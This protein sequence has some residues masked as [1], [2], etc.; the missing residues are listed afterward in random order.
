MS[1]HTLF[2]GIIFVLLLGLAVFFYTGGT[3]VADVRIQTAH[4]SDYP[5]VFESVVGVLRSGSAPQQFSGDALDDV[6]RYTLA[7]INVTLKNRGLFAAEWLDIRVEGAPGDVAVYSLTGEGSTVDAR[8]V[9]EVNLKLLTTAS[10]DTER[11]IR[12][13]YYVYGMK[14]TISVK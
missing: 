14:R 5:E 7:D 4:A 13:Q 6:S 8:G 11:A 1:K 12:I 9:G 10:P 3:L 2:L